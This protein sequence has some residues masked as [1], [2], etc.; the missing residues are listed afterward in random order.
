MILLFLCS[1]A[2]NLTGDGETFLRKYHVP[3]NMTANEIPDNIS[4]QPMQLDT[5]CLKNEKDCIKQPKKLPM[6]CIQ[7][8]VIT[9]SGVNVP[10]NITPT[11]D[12]TPGIIP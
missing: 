6:I 5:E 9:V 1:C 7:C 11:V 2:T 4:I 10:K 8:V 12:L 3:I